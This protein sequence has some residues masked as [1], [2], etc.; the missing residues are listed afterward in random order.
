MKI[1]K[2]EHS[3]LLV[4]MPEPFNRTALFD[5]GTMSEPHVDVNSL[6]WLDD[7]IITHNHPDHMSVELL[8][9]LLLKFPQVRITTTAQGVAQLKQEGITAAHQ[10][11]DGIRFFA[12]PHEDVQP[13][14]PHPEQIGVHYLDRL[15][16]PGDS[17]SFDATMPVLALPVTAPWGAMIKAVNLAIRLRPR[18]VLPVHDWHWRDEARTTTYDSLEQLLAE[19]DITF[20]KPENGKPIVLD[21]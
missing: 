20:L 6:Q 11:I 8:H 14:F 1:T 7:I 10:E 13:A 4:E 17:H 9:R 2:L 3:C 18:Y 12:S 16:H 5:P 21:V 19:H 15:T